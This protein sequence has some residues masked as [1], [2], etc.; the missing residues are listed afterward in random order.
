MMVFYLG[1]VLKQRGYHP[2]LRHFII[3]KKVTNHDNAS[4]P[5]LKQ[6]L[7]VFISVFRKANDRS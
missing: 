5:A 2:G 6:L 3:H 7:F 1:K 4:N